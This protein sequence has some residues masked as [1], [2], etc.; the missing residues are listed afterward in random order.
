MATFSYA[1]FH[2]FLLSF[3][4]FV[5][6]Y[7]SGLSVQNFDLSDCYIR[8]RKKINKSLYYNV[9]SYEDSKLLSFKNN[10]DV[11]LMY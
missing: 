5:G 8:G 9:L 1:G 6:L 3:F 4:P 2:T 11:V 10:N 7:T